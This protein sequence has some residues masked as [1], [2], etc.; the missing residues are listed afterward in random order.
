MN[1]ISCKLQIILS[2]LFLIALNMLV[3]AVIIYSTATMLNLTCV[4][5]NV[6]TKK[7][8]N[9]NGEVY[10]LEGYPDE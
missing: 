5:H 7:V 4:N 3:W 9:Y 6:Y 8:K 10:R 2:K 1:F